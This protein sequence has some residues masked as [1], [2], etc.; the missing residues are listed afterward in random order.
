[1]HLAEVSLSGLAIRIEKL[2]DQS[3]SSLNIS[4]SVFSQ[5]QPITQQK[6]LLSS[7]YVVTIKRPRTSYTTTAQKHLIFP[8]QAETVYSALQLNSRVQFENWGKQGH[9]YYRGEYVK[10]RVEVVSW[11]GSDLN[12][13]TKPAIAHVPDTLGNVSLAISFAKPISF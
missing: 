4:F 12:H 1:M 10:Q 2:S 8:D 7:T 3:E 13:L 5:L 9:L 11:E 6:N